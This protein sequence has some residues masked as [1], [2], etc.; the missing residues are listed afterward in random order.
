LS[1]DNNIHIGNP[2]LSSESNTI[3]IGTGGTGGHTAFYVA[4]V[5]GTNIASGS[6]V[7]ISSTG[8]LGTAS[9]SRRYKDDIQD[10]GEASA[11]LL[12]LRPVTY[13]YKQPAADGSKPIQYG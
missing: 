4:G 7:Y 2:A 13:R 10:M 9:S 1:G 5:L 12:K 3:R 8:Q 6:P 11:G